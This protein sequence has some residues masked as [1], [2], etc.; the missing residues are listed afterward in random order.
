MPETVWD[1]ENEIEHMQAD[2]KEAQE[3][4]ESIPDLEERLACARDRLRVLKRV[5]RWDEP[6]GNSVPAEA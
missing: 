5:T 2:L 4:A 3:R 6:D 1:L